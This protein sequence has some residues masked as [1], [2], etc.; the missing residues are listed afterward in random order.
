MSW[1]CDYPCQTFVPAVCS[2][3]EML[4]RNIVLTS[5]TV[6]P[7][8]WYL[9]VKEGLS[10]FWCKT[11]SHYT[12][13]A[14]TCITW[15]WVCTRIDTHTHT[16]STRRHSHAPMQVGRQAPRLSLR[17]ADPFL[18]ASSR[19]SIICGDEVMHNGVKWRLFTS[20][21]H[22]VKLCSLTELGFEPEN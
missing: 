12:T 7:I 3:S 9:S 8:L 15:R 13:N 20:L 1:L 6:I 16:R 2:D 4:G 10:C 17:H 11:P 19:L 18:S 14:H 21:T 22:N 5:K